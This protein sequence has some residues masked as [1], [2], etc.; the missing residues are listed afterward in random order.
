MNKK[1]GFVLIALLLIAV[2]AAAAVTYPKLSEKYSAETTES[3]PVTEERN[4]EKA[5][6]FTVY[7]KDGKPV[8][9]SEMTGKPTVVNFWA[10]WCGY[11]VEE[12]PAFD[13]AAEKYGDKVNFM[14]VDLTDGMRE[15]QDA[16]LAFLKEKG[17]TFPAYFD[18]DSSAAAAYAVQS[19]PL[20]LFVDKDGCIFK[21]QIGLMEEALLEQ[22]LTVLTEG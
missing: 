7:D 11:C 1:V 14:I 2:L 6:D 5:A 21:V 8:K 9:L 3:V 20:T 4:A 17:Y 10:T 16:A 12:L 13:R 15:T 22:V 18:T 19:I